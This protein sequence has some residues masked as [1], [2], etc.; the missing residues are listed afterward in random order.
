MTTPC[1]YCAA[2]SKTTPLTVLNGYI[3]KKRIKDTGAKNGVGNA[4]GNHQAE[5]KPKSR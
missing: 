5:Q 2:L 3:A 1:S 4:V